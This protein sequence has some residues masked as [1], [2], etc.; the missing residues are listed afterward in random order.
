MGIKTKITK[1]DLSPYIKV[2]SLKK[3]KDG[4]SHSVYIVNNRYILKIYEDL[5]IQEIQNEITIVNYCKDLKINRIKKDLFYIKNKPAI[6]YYK[7]KGKSLTK[8]KKKHIRQ[9]GKFLKEFHTLS[10]NLNLSLKNSFGKTSLKEM[11]KRSKSKK[12]LKIF[13]KIKIDLKNDGII[14]GDL[15][16]DNAIFK[17]DRLSCVIDFSDSCK[18]DFLFDLAVA[19]ISWCKNK[20]D[21]KTLLKSYEAKISIKKF[22]NYIDYALLYYSVL[23]YLNN[24]EYKSLLKGIRFI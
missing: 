12:F 15:F 5:S 6:L 1:K 21:I 22:Y 24:R 13:K 8:I 10:S 11:I 23:R 19:S 9:I 7:C 20:E 17:K 4:V 3:T 18:G 2:D 14:H 16:I